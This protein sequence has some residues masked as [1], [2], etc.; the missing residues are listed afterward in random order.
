MGGGEFNE[1]GDFDGGG[2]FNGGGESMEEG[3]QVG[4]SF[5]DLNVE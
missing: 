1:G 2:E 3:S 5:E 4:S